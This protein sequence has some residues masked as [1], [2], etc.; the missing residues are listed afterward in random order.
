MP[1][2]RVLDENTANQIAAGEV[3]ERPASVVKELLENSFDAGATR[4]TVEI[5]GGGLEEIK[6]TDNGW[7]MDQTDSVTAFQRHATSKI[8]SLSD[9][10]DI[11]SL[12]FRGEALPSIAAVSKILLITR[13]PEEESGTRLEIQ[14]GHLLDKSPEGCPTGTSITV[15]DLFFNTPARLK[16][17][18][19]KSIEAGHITDIVSRLALARPDIGIKLTH[20]GRTSLHTPGTGETVD[21]LAAIYGA[22]GIKNMIALEGMEE[23]MTLRGNISVPSAG[24][25]TKRH[26]TVVINGRY[27]K[28]YIINTAVVE[29]Y[30]TLLPHGRFPVALIALELEPNLLDVNVHPSKT[31]VRVFGESMLFSLVK[32]TV[33]IALR[34]ERVIPGFSPVEQAIE[35]PVTD[36]SSPADKGVTAF[37][38]GRVF[39]EITP[40]REI[41]TQYIFAGE[42]PQQEKKDDFLDSIYPIGFLPPTYI[43]AGSSNGLFIIDHHAAHERILYEKFIKIV[44]SEKID[45]QILLVPIVIQLSDREFQAASENIEYFSSLGLKLHNFG[46]NSFIVREIPAGLPQLSVEDTFRD[47]LEYLIDSGQRAKREDLIKKFAA[48][49]ACKA[50]VK[51]GAKSTL[52]EAWAIINSLKV[53]EVPYACPHGRPT[54]INISDH[55]LKGRFKRT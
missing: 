3:V 20:D 49:A 39:P 35:Q 27:V 4:I 36:Y 37:T 2:I 41:A 26:I 10:E 22:A 50:A 25:S 48:S 38:P 53:M 23:G 43:L 8:V 51:A 1:R 46:T 40:I 17:M 32:R 45:E 54:M 29:G 47:M 5:K 7:G 19:S 21:A 13:P 42:K 6:I 31:V 30:G 15:R 16:Y 28:N 14:G 52:E 33:L 18:K 55:E 24:K 34:T 44:G 12:G 11:C 9:I